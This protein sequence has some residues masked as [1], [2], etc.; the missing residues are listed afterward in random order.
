[1]LR[2]FGELGGYAIE[3]GHE[4]DFNHWAH[5]TAAGTLIV[6]SHRVGTQVH[7]FNE[8]EIDDAADELRLIW[9]YGEGAG[10][11]YP[12]ERGMVA[13]VDGSESRL[14]N[15]GPTGVIVEITGSGEVAWRVKFSDNALPSRSLTGTPLPPGTRGNLVHNNLLINDLYALNRGPE[16]R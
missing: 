4:F 6:S 10:N 9:S 15:Y 3:S 8:F 12:A 13:R 1:V 11:D 16:T 14:A 5:I 2:T 7:L